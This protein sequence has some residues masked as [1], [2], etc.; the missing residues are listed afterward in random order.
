M[1]VDELREFASESFRIAIHDTRP[2][3][4]RDATEMVGTVAELSSNV[5][6]VFA[7]LPAADGCANFL[8]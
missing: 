4:P 2:W 1:V 6:T 3:G 5:T 8:G 7:V